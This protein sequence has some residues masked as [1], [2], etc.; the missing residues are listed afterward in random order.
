MRSFKANPASMV[1]TI[2]DEAT[3]E[4]RKRLINKWRWKGYGPATIMYSDQAVR[5]FNVICMWSYIASP[6]ARRTARTCRGGS[7]P[8]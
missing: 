3:G 8:S 2:I 5:R 4:E 1:S 7:K 6:D